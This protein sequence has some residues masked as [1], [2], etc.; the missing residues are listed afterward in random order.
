MPDL[1]QSSNAMLASGIFGFNW[2]AAIVVVVSIVIGY[3]MVILFGY[4]SDQKAIKDAKDKLK[5]HL[6]AVRL[7][8]DQLGVV[9]RS[10]AGIIKG[11]GRYIL[12]AFKPLLFVIIP[13]TLLMI[14][15]DRYLGSQPLPVTQN[16]LF[17]VQADNADQL[18]NLSLELPQGLQTTAPPLHAVTDNEVV[19]RLA[20]DKNGTY[21]LAVKSGD[22]TYIKRI[23]VGSGLPRLSSI[24]L[25]GNFWE[26]MLYSA[27]P[28][29]P[30]ASP[31]ERMEVRYPAR[32]IR[33]AGF[34]SNWIIAFFVLSLIAG[35]IFKSALGIEI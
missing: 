19:W 31:I 32:D 11:T 10:Y 29:L 23:V 7:F 34:A 8:Q 30:A 3:L 15:I 17:K 20:A 9:V 22:Q 26:R 27:E 24:R 2:P 1:I 35:F 33:F 13:I 16:F 14:Q 28:A 25:R 12:L 5:A 4:T 21:D 18:N 6:L